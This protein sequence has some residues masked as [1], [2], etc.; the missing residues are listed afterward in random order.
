MLMKFLSRSD[1]Q[2]LIDL[3]KLLAIADKPL[4][5]DCLLYTSPSPRD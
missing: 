2:H 1:K 5:W 3:A 4:R